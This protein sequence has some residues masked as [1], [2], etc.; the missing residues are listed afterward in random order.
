VRL[1]NNWIDTSGEVGLALRDSSNVDRLRFYFVGG[2]TNYWIA[3]QQSTNRNTSMGYSSGG[4]LLALRL[5]GPE[6]YSLDNG[7]TP[8]V[9]ALASGGPVTRIAFFNKGAG[10][11]TERNFYI[12]EMSLTEQRTTNV[13]MP[14]TEQTVFLA[15]KADGIPNSWWDQY[16]ISEPNRLALADPDGDGFTHAQEFAFGLVPNVAGGRLVEVSSTNPNKIVFLQRDVGASYVVQAAND[17]ADG[18]TNTVTAVESGDTNNVPAGYKR[19]EAPFPSGSRG[20]LRV[21]A[22]LSP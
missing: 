2:Q 19:Y 7:Y 3:D 8:I 4:Q 18:F 17:L 1:D 11:G 14:L 6:S 16:S 12:G 5:T 22:T 15:T 21:E 9:G 20:F 13:I 10:P